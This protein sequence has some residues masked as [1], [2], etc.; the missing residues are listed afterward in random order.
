[1]KKIYI[2]PTSR[3]I[4]LHE[5]A[6]LM[7]TGSNSLNVEITDENVDD[8]NKTRQHSGASLWDYWTD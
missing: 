6:E 8:D 2:H 7:E 4:A 3:Y 5:E 1:M